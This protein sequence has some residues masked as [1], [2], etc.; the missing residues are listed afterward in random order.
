MHNKTFY[1]L[2]GVNRNCT[3]HQLKRAYYSL[4]KQFHPDS[5][6]VRNDQHFRTI[7]NAYQVLSDPVQRAEYDSK[8]FHTFIRTSGFDT[9]SGTYNDTTAKSNYERTQ[10]NFY[11]ER[12]RMH[13]SFYRDDTETKKKQMRQLK[14]GLLVLCGLAVLMWTGKIFLFQKV[15]RDHITSLERQQAHAAS[16]IGKDNHHNELK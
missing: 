16:K 2:L 11:E 1:E 4:A 9:G 10:W 7:T 6:N 8:T 14:H 12:T 13:N 3:K 15:Y 5:G